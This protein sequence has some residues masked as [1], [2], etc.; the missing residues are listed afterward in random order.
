MPRLLLSRRGRRDAD[1]TSSAVVGVVDWYGATD[2][3]TMAAQAMPTAI[4]RSDDPDSRE[5]QLLG[6]PVGEAPELARRASPVNDVRASLRARR[7]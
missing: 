1:G 6:V 5:S 3:T 2:L 4:A 7:R